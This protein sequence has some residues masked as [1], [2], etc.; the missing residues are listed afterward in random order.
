M[1]T[2]AQIRSSKP[3]A[4]KC[5]G[6]KIIFDSFREIAFWKKMFFEFQKYRIYARKVYF[7]L[8]QQE[9][10]PLSEGFQVS[11]F[12]KHSFRKIYDNYLIIFSCF[13]SWCFLLKAL[14]PRGFF[15]SP[16][17]GNLSMSKKTMH[18]RWEKH[19]HWY[20]SRLKISLF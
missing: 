4:R 8:T 1:K 5:I 12:F 9:C 15:W 19:T 16:E 18:L 10:I 13:L 3:S 7:K 11:Y 14:E 20:F 2:G 17:S 6:P